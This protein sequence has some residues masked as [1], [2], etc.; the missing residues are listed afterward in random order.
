MPEL[1]AAPL[2][3]AEQRWVAEELTALAD[4]GVDVSDARALGEHHAG[5]WRRWSAVGGDA[6]RVVNRT[7]IGVGEHLVRR[8]G[9]VWVVVTD[10]LGTDLAVLGQPGDL[11]VHP[12]FLVAKRWDAE[13]HGRL[14]DVVDGIAERVQEVLA[15]R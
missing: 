9:L 7:A 6:N 13:Q 1:G 4:A 3:A 11:L 8:C 10:D 2:N 15:D 5:Q 14:A 12:I